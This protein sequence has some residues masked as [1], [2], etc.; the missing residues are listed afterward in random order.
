MLCHE[1]PYDFLTSAKLRIQ[2]ADD[3]RFTMKSPSLVQCA[4]TGLDFWARNPNRHLRETAKKTQQQN[5]MI[6]S[7]T[8]NPFPLSA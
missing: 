3:R 6:F 4:S 7:Y 2:V 1:K 5:E 8:E